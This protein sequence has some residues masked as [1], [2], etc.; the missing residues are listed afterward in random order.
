M[1]TVYLIRHGET[2]FNQQKKIQG[3]CDSPLTAY[4]VKQAYIAKEHIE[5]LNIS[6]DK[7]YTS[8]AERAIDTM[9]ILID[10]PYKR[11][12]GLK[13]WNF[14]VF[15]GEG[16]HLSPPQPYKDYFVK[17][18]GEDEL[19]FRNRINTTI[20]NL[21]KASN[22]DNILVVFHGAAMGQFYLQWKE[23]S[24][25]RQKGRIKNCSIFKYEYIE[26]EFTLKEIIDHDFSAI[27]HLR[28]KGR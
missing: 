28:I 23:N 18:G 22:A 1:K 24:D 25:I 11:L 6:F 5:S 9:E 12:K 20:T 21:V 8:T 10:G 19:E 15:E 14:G 26:N 7:A 2:L 3:F 27:E 16:E 13:E 17:Y 4:G